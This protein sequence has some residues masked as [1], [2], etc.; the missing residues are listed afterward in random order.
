MHP[1]AGLEINL[2]QTSFVNLISLKYIM[3]YFI[4][5][6]H[7][8]MLTRFFYLMKHSHEDTNQN[9]NEEKKNMTTEILSS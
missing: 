9:L 2:Q 8:Q 4:I 1:Q 6:I 3:H 5:D 7:H